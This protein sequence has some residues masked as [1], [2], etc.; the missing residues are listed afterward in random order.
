MIDIA[1]LNKSLKAT[2]I[3]KYLESGNHGKWKNFFNLALGKYGGSPL[4]N[5]N[6]KDIDKLKIEDPLIKEIAEIWSYTF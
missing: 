2:W 4:R 1:S 5:L 3:I 6:R